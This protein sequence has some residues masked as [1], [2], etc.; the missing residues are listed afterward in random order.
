MTL[1]R[2]QSSSQP[3]QPPTKRPL[4]R[5]H[6]KTK[7]INHEMYQVYT[8]HPTSHTPHHTL[9]TTT[10]TTPHH[11]APHA[12]RPGAQSPPRQTTGGDR[13]L[14]DCS[15]EQSAS[16]NFPSTWWQ[17]TFGNRCQ[18]AGVAPPKPHQK[19]QDEDE[20]EL[21]EDAGFISVCWD[22]KKGALAHKHYTRQQCRSTSSPGPA[23]RL[24]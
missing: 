23:S 1:K 13:S 9:H 12:P 15:G 2:M 17:T 4:A 3:A 22:C 21:E 24:G 5:I 11:T 6:K 7:S 14:G 18:G 8:L 16:A 19:T 20:D 10:H